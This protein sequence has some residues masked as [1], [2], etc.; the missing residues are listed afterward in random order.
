MHID[1]RTLALVLGITHIIQVLVFTHQYATNKTIR[2]VGWWLMWSAA[3][4]AGFAC[5]LL[6]GIPS[7]DAMAVF[8]QNAL[9]VLGVFF[10]YIGIMRFLD[11]KENRRIVVSIFTVFLLSFFYF[12][13]VDNDIQVRGILISAALVTVSFLSAQG[14]FVNKTPAITGSANFI[15]AVF[16]AHGCYFAL[17]AVMM[18][19]G[20]A[21]DQYDA[22]TLFNAAGYMDALIVSI[23]LTFGLI[24]MINQRLNAE[25]SE[26]KEHFELIF[27]TSP[28]ASLIARLNDG[29]IAN[30]NDGFTAL[31]GF[32]REETVGKSTLDI[33][34]WKDPVDRQKILDELVQKGFCENLEVLFQRKDGSHIIGMMSA[35]LITLQG[36]PHIVSITRDITNRKQ[37]EEAL[38]ESEARYRAVTH[39]ATDGIITVDYA[40]NIVDW[41]R[42][43]KKIFGYTESEICGQPVIRLIPS[44]YRDRHLAGMSRMQADEMPQVIDKNVELEGLRKDMSE[45]PIELS[46]A[47]WETAGVRFYTAILRDISERKQYQEDLE[48][49]AIH[50]PL[51]GL[52]N[53]HSLEDILNRTIA[54]AKRGAMSSL[55]YMDLDNFKDVNDTVGHAAGDEVLIN[56]SGF[57][58][59]EV[60][61]EDVAFRLG[62]DEFAVLLDGIKL[63]EALPAAERLRVF[64]EAHPFEL[65]GRVF[66]L[67]LSIGIIEINGTLTM[68]ELLSQADAAMYRAKEQGKNRVEVFR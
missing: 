62:G 32:P 4:A 55:L 7:I 28:D 8:A 38:R 15:T 46:L 66:P 49:L 57:L 22:P 34:L 53:R 64:V 17:R 35:K 3:E 47:Q 61:T 9:I 24:I 44:R 65:H 54:K 40:G 37:A 27:N 63:R 10:L 2:G 39:S 43:A 5:M 6:R 56:L 42:G 11:R 51:T 30:I 18:L 52:L 23:L 1:I 14:L 12:V 48:Y 19:A 31:T 33:H 59:A 21:I 60:R 58:K 50:D 26:T 41:N 67:S 25:I 68:G 45:V 13:W 36:L 20:T 16:I 29:I